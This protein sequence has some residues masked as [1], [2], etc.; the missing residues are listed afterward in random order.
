MFIRARGAARIHC[1]TSGP[2]IGK[3]THQSPTDGLRALSDPQ[4]VEIS[5]FEVFGCSWT[6]LAGGGCR[7][8]APGTSPP[9]HSLEA[10]VEN[11][12]I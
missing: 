12:F 8:C 11:V 6:T 7:E 5:E 2:F 1:R 10:L 4:E 9:T 3:T